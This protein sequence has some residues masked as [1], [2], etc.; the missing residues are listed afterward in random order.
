MDFITTV[1]VPVEEDLDDMVTKSIKVVINIDYGVD[2]SW[3]R[4]LEELWPT[5]TV[6]HNIDCLISLIPVL[7]KITGFQILASIHRRNQ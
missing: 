5:Q 3:V 6:Y 2:I 1:G 4:S 7:R